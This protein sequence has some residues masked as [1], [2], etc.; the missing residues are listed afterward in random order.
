M[1]SSK[2]KDGEKRTA[3]YACIK[4][5]GASGCGAT[6]IV[7]EPLDQL[8]TD[9]VIHRLNTPAMTRA[10]DRKP[11]PPKVDIDLAQIERDL[12][13]IAADFGAGEISRREWYAARKP[14][15]ERLSRARRTIDAANGTT[16]LAPFRTGDVRVTWDKLEIDRKRVVLETLI[17]RITVQPA[18]KPGQR[19]NSDRIDV[20]W[21]S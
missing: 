3:R 16:A 20:D 11:K 17:H 6:T 9:A 13:G 2:H 12:E 14:L 5:P 19:F 15:E 10:L 18:T 8:I 21:K 7:A 1:W 4:R